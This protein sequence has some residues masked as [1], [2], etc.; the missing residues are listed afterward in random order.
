M[1]SAKEG[2][3]QLRAP[4]AELS[5]PFLSVGG[6]T[7]GTPVGR[8][9]AADPMQAGYICWDTN[10]WTSLASGH[11]QGEA[12]ATGALH[13]I[14]AS[15]NA[16]LQFFS[17]LQLEPLGILFDLFASIALISAIMVILSR[18]PI[19]SVIFLILVFCNAT[20]LLI[21]LR[22]EFLAMMFLIVYVGAIAVLFLFVVMM[23]SIKVHEVNENLW[24]YLPIGGIISVSLIF[25]INLALVLD[26]DFS[27][28]LNW[29]S[30][31]GLID[32]LGSS[33]SDP[34]DIF[35]RDQ[36]SWSALVD[37]IITTNIESLGYLLYTY[38]FYHFLIASLILL[39][40]MIGAIVL[41]LCKRRNASKKQVI[42]QQVGRNFGD[43][44][45]Y[46]G[47]LLLPHVKHDRSQE[48]GQAQR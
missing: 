27:S 14:L 33:A 12:I 1:A 10:L 23:L 35:F 8:S 2:G 13:G 44:I 9:K 6:T 16:P 42:F 28:I 38:Y 25:L 21:L 26:S 11:Q 22:T 48:Q 47:L 39:V 45:G 32:S 5:A 46:A 18:N 17:Q 29:G 4:F 3:Q 34:E 30:K 40:A 15:P 37:P 31:A 43:A 24:R 19:H 41:T 36:R 7:G 20:G